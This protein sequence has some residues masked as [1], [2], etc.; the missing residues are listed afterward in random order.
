[1]QKI[2][3]YDTKLKNAKEDYVLSGEDPNTGNI[4]DSY[5]IEGFNTVFIEIDDK[6]EKIE[7]IYDNS[8]LVNNEDYKRWGKNGCWNPD[9]FWLDHRITDG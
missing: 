2:L 5:K 9:L 7:V 8:T 1:M 6:G 3:A 4:I